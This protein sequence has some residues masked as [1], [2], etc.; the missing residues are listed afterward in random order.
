MFLCGR[1]PLNILHRPAPKLPEVWLTMS[2]HSQTIPSSHHYQLL[3]VTTIALCAHP[4]HNSLMHSQRG[5]TYFMH[6]QTQPLAA[7]SGSSRWAGVKM[8][9]SLEKAQ[10]TTVRCSHGVTQGIMRTF[11]SLKVYS[12]A[13]SDLWS[14]ED[15]PGEHDLGCCDLHRANETKDWGT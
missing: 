14:S 5:V 11:L 2:K 15:P 8:R 7:L 6:R 4:Q 13:Q 1:E 10:S 3:T 12:W 9:G